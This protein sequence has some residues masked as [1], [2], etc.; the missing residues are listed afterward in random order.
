M[1]DFAHIDNAKRIK[2]VS[3]SKLYRPLMDKTQKPRLLSRFISFERKTGLKP[4]TL[5]LEG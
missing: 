3:C 2:K 1:K 4:A 5:S